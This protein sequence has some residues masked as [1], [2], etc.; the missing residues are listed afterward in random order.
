MAI[1]ED[2]LNDFFNNYFLI[3]NEYSIEYSTVP[4]KLN[5]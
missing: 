4:D 1:A 5:H 2:K 3:D